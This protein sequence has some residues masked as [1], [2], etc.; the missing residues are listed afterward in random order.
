MT[1]QI[2]IPDQS[3]VD[4]LNNAWLKLVQV[5]KVKYS[6]QEWS[7]RKDRLIR[8][9][10][11]ICIDPCRVIVDGIPI[12]AV[13]GTVILC[14]PGQWIETGG[15]SKAEQAMYFL[16]FEQGLLT[17]EDAGKDTNTKPNSCKLEYRI[18]ASIRIAGMIHLYWER[19][20]T[21][22]QMRVQAGFYELLAL[23][24]EKIEHRDTDMPELAKQEIDSRYKEGITVDELASLSGVSR[25]HLMR[26][27]KERYGKSIVEYLTEVRLRHAKKLMLESGLS[28]DEI[29]DRV[30]FRSES[31]FRAVFKK[32]VGIAPAV[33]L[34]NRKRRVAAY[35]WPILGSLLPLQVIPYAAPVDHYWTDEFNRKY[36][37]DIE[38]PLGHHY[39]FNRRALRKAKPDC[40]IGLDSTISP[41][42]AARLGEIAPVLLLPWMDADWRQHLLMT[43]DFLQMNEAAA[44]WLERYEQKARSVRE[45]IHSVVGDKKVL[46]LKV[47]GEEM[48]IWGRKAMTVLYDDL[49]LAPASLMNQ[50]DWYEA[51][52]LE[53]LSGCD[54]NCLFVVSVNE[55]LRSQAYWKQLQED[56]GW[57]GLRPVRENKVYLQSGHPAWVYPWLENSALYHERQ[58]A[59]VEHLI[60]CADS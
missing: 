29:A 55:D 7:F 49:G 50:I 1:A 53:R 44:A 19:F 60:L 28:V 43:A 47:A 14:C 5:E 6:G 56:E 20:T 16:D 33:Y 26:G 46:V 57:R 52:E 31:Y 35:S 21:A 2:N 40:I 38:V 34:R 54:E 45:R 18:P 59:R 37:G 39:D 36:S 10:M 25:Y 3:S 9:R 4:L 15:P 24:I 13:T 17:A 48:Q 41:D 42:E 23:L 32:E 12:S 22:D 51:V 30:G 58:L 8:Y 27:F 11:V